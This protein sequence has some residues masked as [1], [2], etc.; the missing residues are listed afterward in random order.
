MNRLDVIFLSD[1]KRTTRDFLPLYRIIKILKIPRNYGILNMD[2]IIA[3][4]HQ[5]SSAS[6]YYK[7][8]DLST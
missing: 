1:C 8:I 2:F 4:L 5:T 6:L 7:N 3:K